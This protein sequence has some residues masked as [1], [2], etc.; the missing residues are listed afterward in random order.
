[1]SVAAA[2]HNL[3]RL[4]E[5]SFERH[6]DHPSL[7]F[8]GTWRA[9]GELVDRAAR[10][11][12]GLR[13][14]GVAPGDRVV[15]MMEN[16]TDVPVVYQAVWR[17]GAVVTPVIFL[18][19]AEALHRIL[20]DAEPVAVV[21]SDAFR[22]TVERAAA[23]VESVRRIVTV[24]AD[25]DE[26][27]AASPAPIASGADDDLAALIYTGGTTGRAKGVMLSHRNLWE[28]GRA[29][30]AAGHVPGI[31]RSLTALPLSHAYGLLVMVV[32]LHAHEPG[33]AVLMRWFDPAAWLSLAQ[34]HRVQITAVVPSMLQLL[35][36]QPLEE[37]DLSELRFVVCG[38]APLPA[39][40]AQKFERRVPSAAIREG[41]GL[42][43]STAIVSGN[44]PGRIRPGSVGVPVD[45]V[46][47]R[48]DAPP[49]EVGEI[50]V[51]SATVMQGYWR[52][53]ELTGETIRDGWLHTGD[54][55]RLDEDGY[56]YVVDRMKDI[57]IR[58]G[59]NVFP[60]D[61]E[62]AL[63]EHPSVEAVA[64]VGRPDAVQG[65]EVVAFVTGEIAPEDLVAYA[66][67]QIGGYKYPREVHVVEALP[68]TPI[69]KVDRKNLR[70]R[71]RP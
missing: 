26:L 17:A 52:D 33:A 27:A 35:L 62:E 71:L 4:A 19:P 66:K 45:G 16:Q 7:W 11:A 37:Y 43:E 8:E 3:A 25:L 14:L 48:I 10:V 41:Y 30:E 13:E 57:I 53:P 23:G 21:T 28:A 67:Q 69:G 54:L 60:R 64:V 24:G 56:L 1:V 42:S 5:E 58:G 38:A 46:E 40:V 2:T 29:G 22:A 63:L 15:V 32:G 47:V 59:F 51:R 65:E 55:G 20:V 18:L 50:C 44:P 12:G 6:G 39:E 31:V 34:E 49:G 36:A 68:L 9:S 70:A 61:V